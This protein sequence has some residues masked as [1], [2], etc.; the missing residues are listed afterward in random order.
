MLSDDVKLQVKH[1][2]DIVDLIESYF[3]LQKSG[4]RFRARCPFHSRPSE[5]IAAVA[6]HEG[7]WVVQVETPSGDRLPQRSGIL[8]Q[9]SSRRMITLSS[10]LP[11]RSRALATPPSTSRP[12]RADRR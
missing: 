4:T 2:T 8:W 6:A 5:L 3:P 11:E 10:S 9:T 12:P 1:A 7:K